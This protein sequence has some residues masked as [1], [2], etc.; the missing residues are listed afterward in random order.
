[1]EATHIYDRVYIYVQSVHAL[2]SLHI[3][4]IIIHDIALYRTTE[5]RTQISTV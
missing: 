5:H 3:R 4:I 1:M 2:L